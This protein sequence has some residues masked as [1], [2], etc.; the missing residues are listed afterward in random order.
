[1][2]GLFIGASEELVTQLLENPGYR[3]I[4]PS[5]HIVNAS[6]LVDRG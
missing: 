1:M 5:A 2:P 4:Q 3:I 6:I